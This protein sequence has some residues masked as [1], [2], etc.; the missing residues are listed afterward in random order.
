MEWAKPQ[1]N[2][3][4]AP[5]ERLRGW[6]ETRLVAA[7]VSMWVREWFKWEENGNGSNASGG[8]GTWT[9]R[10][11]DSEARA[12]A[13]WP[14]GGDEASAGASWFPFADGHPL[15]SY[16][17]MSLSFFRYKLVYEHPGYDPPVW[18]AWVRL[19]VWTALGMKFRVCVA[20]GMTLREWMSIW[21]ACGSQ[22]LPAVYFSSS[23]SQWHPGLRMGTSWIHLST[24][25]Y[26]STLVS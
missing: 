25:V 12:A 7:R 16:P 4:K 1:R 18:T 3:I 5:N 14:L 23:F 9:T 21:A 26:S 8:F 11:P 22:P 13:A 20:M 6:N 19:W 10:T 15:P 17:D 24:S 2:V